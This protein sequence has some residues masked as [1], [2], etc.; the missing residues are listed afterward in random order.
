MIAVPKK[1]QMAQEPRPESQW[2]EAS[3]SGAESHLR[4]SSGDPRWRL[5][6]PSKGV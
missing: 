4:R 2:I 6:V 1:V 3:V 5:E